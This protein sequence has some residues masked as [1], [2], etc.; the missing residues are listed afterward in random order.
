[1]RAPVLAFLACAGPVLAQS[2]AQGV[3][4]GQQMVAVPAGAAVPARVVIPPAGT[5]IAPA[6]RVAAVPL[7]LPAPVAVAAAGSGG[8]LLGL[9]GTAAA[10]A[11][12]AAA[13]LLSGS[14]TSTT[15]TR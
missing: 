7:F 4:A 2:P 6:A 9:G 13:S 11:G 3:A 5:T 14:T 8:S 15:S 10:V 1:M 12:I